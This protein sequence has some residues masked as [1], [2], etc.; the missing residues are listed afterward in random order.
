MGNKFCSSCGAVL[1]EQGTFCE[2]CGALAEPDNKSGPVTIPVQTDF[3]P[4][5]DTITMSGDR[6]P[7][8]KFPVKIIAGI[9][10]ISIV[11][12]AAFLILAP[13]LSGT[14]TQIPVQAGPVV[15]PSPVLAAVTT[16]PVTE[17]TTDTPTPAA[18]PEPE[19]M[20]LKTKFTF[21]SGDVISE[22]TV[23]RYW[24]NATYQWHNDM[25]NHYYVQKARDGYK[26]L[27]IFVNMENKGSTRVWPP[28]SNSIHL[29]Y[30]DREYF[31]DQ[32]HYLP[33]KSVN[34]KATPIEIKEIQY[35]SKLT[36]SEYVEDYGYSHGSKLAYL[37]PGESN[38]IDGYLIY[39]VPDYV[40]PEKIRIRIDFNGKDTGVWKLA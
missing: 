28:G 12:F 31:P 9:L 40:K 37:Y 3:D 29:L 36:G 5:A 32:N 4:L 19:A 6:P 2:Q 33:D 14:T 16:I 13:K 20:P 30:D 18:L 21:G 1:P 22:G 11:A 38:A 27:I 10:C 34:I 39:E 17:E 7:A 23:Y 25:D 35:I 26:Y 15:T 8:K 24:M